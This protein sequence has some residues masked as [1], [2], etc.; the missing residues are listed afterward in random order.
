[1]KSFFK[2]FFL[3]LF[4]FALFSCSN[5]TDE[6]IQTSTFE[7]L[8]DETIEIDSKITWTEE[9]EKGRLSEKL[10]T[11]DGLGNKVRKSVLAVSAVKNQAEEIFPSLSDFGSLD[12][13]L[14]PL[15]LKSAIAAFC[16]AFSKNQ[17]LSAFSRKESLYSLALFFYDLNENLP[18]YAIFFDSKEKNEN[19]AENPNGNSEEVSKDDS[20]NPEKSDKI[21]KIEK[22]FFD[23]YKIGE[24]FIDGAN[25]EIP[26]I[27]FSHEKIITLETYWT[28]ENS[29]WLL[30]QIQISQIRN[31]Q[32][33]ETLLKPESEK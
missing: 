19:L 31:V 18:E 24:P 29:K 27:L 20:V 4:S 7:T 32:K 9:M 28:L 30:D 33:N 14:I 16:E 13:R 15:N 25:Y 1:M 21:E 6:K 2:F 12:T 5:S 26:L 23:S 22:K 10:K 3:P 17:S 8:K 11:P